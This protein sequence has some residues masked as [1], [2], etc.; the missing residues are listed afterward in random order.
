MWDTRAKQVLVFSSI[1]FFTYVLIKLAIYFSDIVIILGIS[2][3]SAYLLISP[4][5]FFTRFVKIRALG[6]MIVYLILIASLISLV[7]FLG[8]ILAEEFTGLYKNIPKFITNI[9]EIINKVQLKLIS[10]SIPIDLSALTDSIR[11]TFNKSAINQ[12]GKIL[13]AAIGTVHALVYF[14]VVSVISYYFLLDGHNMIEG[15]T[16]QFPKKIQRDMMILASKIDKCLRGFYGGMV[17]LAAI[18]AVVMFSTY[19]IMDLPY[20]L[21]LALWHFVACIIPSV[22]G[23][24]GLVPACLVLGF[25]NPK[26]IWLPIVVYELFTRLIKENFIVPRVMGNAIGIHPV[27]VLIAV[28]AGLKAAGIIGVIFAL[29]LFGVINVTL[30][31]YLGKIKKTKKRIA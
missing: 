4:V 11:T 6:V 18:N 24:L 3:L 21:L 31:H 25:T 27:L 15:F 20:A 13:S 10:N 17:K 5:D 22:G 1:I 9:E 12:I 8:P 28:F 29:P 16:K 30:S 2:V 7:I 26:L 14:I 19:I 23:W